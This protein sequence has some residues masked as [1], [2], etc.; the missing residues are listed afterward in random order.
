MKEV[1]GRKGTKD[2]VEKT[3]ERYIQ[4]EIDLKKKYDD[5]EGVLFIKDSMELRIKL[6][7]QLKNDLMLDSEVI[8]GI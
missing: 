3:L 8:W 1:V 5:S 4:S 7:K 2:F 6:L